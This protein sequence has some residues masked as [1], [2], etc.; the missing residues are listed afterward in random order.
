[1]REGRGG[2]KRAGEGERD[3]EGEKHKEKEIVMEGREGEI[4]GES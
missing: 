3:G 1:M 4:H 2:R